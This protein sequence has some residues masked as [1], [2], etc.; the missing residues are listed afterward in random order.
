LEEDINYFA[1]KPQN[2]KNRVLSYTAV[3]HSTG[4]IALKIDS[5]M[6]WLL[7]PFLQKFFICFINI[8]SKNPIFKI[9]IS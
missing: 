2:K 8:I 9:N 1:T 4:D 5:K 7:R 3:Q 6:K